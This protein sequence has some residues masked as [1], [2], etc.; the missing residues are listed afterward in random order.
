[1]TALDV[2]FDLV[3]IAAGEAGQ[4]AAYL[5]GD[6]GAREAI[7]DR[8]LFGGSCPRQPA[9]SRSST[10]AARIPLGAF[11]AGSTVTRRAG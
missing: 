6:R 1:M 8:E 3:I 4:A 7:V 11:I 10:I 9:T 2:T 5:A